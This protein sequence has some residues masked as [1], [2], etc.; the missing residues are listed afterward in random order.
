MPNQPCLGLLQQQQKTKG[1]ELAET[2][3]H[4]SMRLRSRRKRRGDTV[5]YNKLQIP[6]VQT[7]NKPGPPFPPLPMAPSPR[8]PR[9]LIL[10]R[11]NGEAS[12]WICT[13][14]SVGGGEEFHLLR[15]L[16]VQGFLHAG[17][18]TGIKEGLGFLGSPS[19]LQARTIHVGTLVDQKG[20]SPHGERGARW[21][22]ARPACQRTQASW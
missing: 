17:E 18:K 12:F 14:Q 6:P 9:C 19:L 4:F 20:A 13:L 3:Y 11:M 5:G 16:E 8:W 7:L 22:V 2:A 15:P 1:P 21:A 10:Q